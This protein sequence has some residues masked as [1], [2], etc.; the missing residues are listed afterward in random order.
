MAQRE[1]EAFEASGREYAHIV[2][3]VLDCRPSVRCQLNPDR[4][5]VPWPGDQLG[6]DGE[7][8]LG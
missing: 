5:V 6:L 2:R 1:Q 8:L 3:A 4:Q 7:R